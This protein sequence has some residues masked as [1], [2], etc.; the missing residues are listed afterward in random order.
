MA[1]TDEDRWLSVDEIRR[2]P[3]VNNDTIYK[4]I[5]EK[6][7]PASR[8]G[9]LWKLKISDFDEWVRKGGGSEEKR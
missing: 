4:L 9:P 5:K 1:K 8:V 6:G 3:G 7:M 2:Y